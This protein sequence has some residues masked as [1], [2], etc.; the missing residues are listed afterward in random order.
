MFSLVQNDFDFVDT[1]D[2]IH[3][4]KSTHSQSGSYK[5]SVTISS[6]APEQM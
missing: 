1:F 4:M 6:V 2:G 5:L 3:Y